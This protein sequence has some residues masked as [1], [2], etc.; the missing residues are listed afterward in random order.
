MRAAIFRGVLWVIL[1][2][3]L[4]SFFIYPFYNPCWLVLV[5]WNMIFIF[6]NIWDVILPIEYFSRWLKPPTSLYLGRPR[7]NLKMRIIW[8]ETA[9]GSKSWVTWGGVNQ[10]RHFTNRN[11]RS[12]HIWVQMSKGQ[13]YGR[14]FNGMFISIGTPLVQKT[15]RTLTTTKWMI[16]HWD[17]DHEIRWYDHQ[18]NSAFFV[19]LHK[20]TWIWI[21]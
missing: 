17:D 15:T 2:T 18:I 6:H 20:S 7:S 8:A 11:V 3:T 4:L 13:N 21:N 1:Y 16:S 19:P 9:L 14:H 5:V 10:Q 12:L